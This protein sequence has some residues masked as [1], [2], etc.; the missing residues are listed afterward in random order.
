MREIKK[1]AGDG[2]LLTFAQLIENL[3]QFTGTSK[4]AFAAE[5]D[6]APSTLSKI[7]SSYK[8]M[9]GESFHSFRNTAATFFTNRIF[10]NHLQHN[11][12]ALFPCICDFTTQE[13]LSNFLSDAILYYY[14]FTVENTS[15]IEP[16]KDFSNGYIFSGKHRIL[17][18]LFLTV[19]DCLRETKPRDINVYT[20]VWLPTLFIEPVFDR[21]RL[22]N[23]NG[24][25]II[26]HQLF[27]PEHIEEDGLA[28]FI[29]HLERFS[30]SVDFRF[31]TTTQKSHQAFMLVPDETLILFNYMTRLQPIVGY[32]NDKLYLKNTQNDYLRLFHTKRTMEKERIRARLYELSGES[33][34]TFFKDPE[35]LLC[36]TPIGLAY[37]RD[38]I[39]AV[40]KDEKLAD[41]YS[42]I[43]QHILTN[44]NRFYISQGVADQ[45]L[46]TGDIFFPLV[47]HHKIETTD[48][49][50]YF[51]LYKRFQNFTRDEIR[52]LRTRKYLQ[53]SCV[54][55]AKKKL[56]IYTRETGSCSER[57]H[58]LPVPEDFVTSILE[59]GI[60]KEKYY[61]LDIDS[62]SF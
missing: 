37:D 22:S 4:T 57:L 61:A 40:L 15:H 11:M 45:V 8:M 19:S 50:S 13:T 43:I 53:L 47:G 3:L 12:I 34:L 5:L 56:I 18:L 27:M 60:Y 17:N 52:I 62:L 9:S 38:R 35:C 16:F 54:L 1:K 20:N 41:R 48:R 28:N 25:R 24:H 21:I 26:F 59:E 31:Y 14:R 46:A 7:L 42:A 39:T 36:F 10:A 30:R 29:F 44:I 23:E 32:V 51:Q 55:I 6:L 2:Y 49:E 33:D 58:F